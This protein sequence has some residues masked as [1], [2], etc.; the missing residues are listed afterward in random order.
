MPPA[1]RLRMQRQGAIEIR[2]YNLTALLHPMQQSKLW[3]HAYPANHPQNGPAL[4]RPSRQNRTYNAPPASY[5]MA[6]NTPLDSIVLPFQQWLRHRPSSC[7]AAITAGCDTHTRCHS[8]P[9][10]LPPCAPGRPHATHPG[11]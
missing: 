10:H 1:S 6:A 4:E 9:F 5:F 2:C 7:D 11:P 3:I 8:R